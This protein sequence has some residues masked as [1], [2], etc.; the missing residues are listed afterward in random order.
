MTPRAA[1]PSAPDAASPDTRTRILET[2]R[3]LFHEQGYAATGVSTILREAD[4]FSGSLYHFF[5]SKEALLAA[6]LEHYGTLLEPI[7][8]G[9]VERATADPV[10]RVFA[11]LG[12][13]R[14][15]LEESGC[16][17]GC[18]IGNLALEVSDSHP[19]VRPLIEANFARWTA[20][21]ERWL[22]GARDRLPR[23]TDLGALAR[24]VLTVM[25]GAVMQARAAG[26]I[27][28]FDASV[29]E[30]RRHFDLIASRARDKKR[31]TKR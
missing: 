28:P 11:L 22:G 26:S 27:A 23:G 17:M 14:R 29:A 4:V 10:E 12:F 30:L 3:R 20:T 31:R 7:V 8:T 2:A 1:L 18:P 25:E 6:V 21:V 13:Y 24:F 15:G 16:R 5:P 19:E 9:P